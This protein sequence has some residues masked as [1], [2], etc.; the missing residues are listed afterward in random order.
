MIGNK[1]FVGACALAVVLAACS[2]DP[3]P[4]PP[5]QIDGGTGADGGP[6]PPPPPPCTG[7]NHDRCDGACVNLSADTNHCGACGVACAEGGVCTFG[8]CSCPGGTASCGDTCAD[9]QQDARHCGECGRACPTGTACIGGACITQCPPG[10]ARCGSSCHALGSDSQNCGSCGNACTGARTCQ[11]GVCKCLSGQVLCGGQCT[12]TQLDASNC[13]GCGTQCFSGFQCQ[14]GACVCPQGFTSCGTSCVD[15]HSDV[16]NCGGCNLFCNPGQQCVGGFCDTPCPPGYDKCGAQCVNTQTSVAHCGACGVGC[17]VGES[18]LNGV[19]GACNSATTD[20]DGD[21]WTVA[22]GDC[23]DQ[24]GMGCG[25]D[26]AWVNPGAV[27]IPFNGIDDNCNGLVDGQDTLDLEHCDLGIL[28]DTGSAMDFA[29]AI[30][31]CRATTENPSMA[32]KTW[33]VIDAKLLHADGSPITSGTGHSVRQSFGAHLLPKE[34]RSFVVLS[35]GAAADATQT[36]PGPN[37]GPDSTSVDNDS[38]WNG[39]NIQSCTQPYCIS[40]WFGTGTPPLKLAGKLPEAPGCS[41]SGFGNPELARNSVMLVLRMRAPTNARAFQFSANFLSSEYPEF[42]CTDYNDQLVAL[43]D[44][45]GGFPIG[46]SNPIDKNLMTYSS[47][48]Q[49][50]PVGINVAKGTGLFRVCETSAQ[51]SVCWDSDV[52]TLSCAFGPQEL[53]GT[54]YDWGTWDTCLNGG[55]TGWLVTSGNIRPGE[56]VELR[57]AIWDVGDTALDSTALIDNFQWLQTPAQPGTSD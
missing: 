24:T 56:I 38:N 25:N 40:D 36:N 5:V 41:T 3:G 28:S 9:L 27:E 18:C 8:A 15:T 57:I 54:G 22:D 50:W 11:E 43:V 12:D 42:V 26:P 23:C 46:A 55:G 33:G 1:L 52:S 53:V 35:S 51:N 37:Q 6:P 7:A 31:L 16:N 13:G 48:G 14:A 34:G 20:C 17:P 47:Q 2:S 49:R 30:G 29:R 32:D 19:C 44:T 4:I 21:G 10:E 39:V 45:P